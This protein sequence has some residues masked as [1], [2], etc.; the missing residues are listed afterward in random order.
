MSKSSEDYGKSW[1]HFVYKLDHLFQSTRVSDKNSSVT[2]TFHFSKLIS[3]QD[4]F[5]IQHATFK[6]TY[7][8]FNPFWL[9]LLFFMHLMI[10]F[11]LNDPEIGKHYNCTQKRLKLGMVSSFDPHNMCTKV[12]RVTTKTGW[13]S[14]KNWTISFKVRG[15]QMK[16]HLFQR[17]FIFLNSFQLRLFFH[18]ICTIQSYILKFQPFLTTF[19]IFHAFNDL[20]WAKW[21]CNWKALQLNSEKVE[22]WNGIKI[23]PT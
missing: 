6:A 23:W 17:H 8:N 13:T 1:M 9:H 21:P 14:C 3:T 16:T 5:C 19:A 15:F 7:W 22:T 11:E 12:E 18:S 2:K 20:F 10:Y 4:F